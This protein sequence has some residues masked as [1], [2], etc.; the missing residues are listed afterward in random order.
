VNARVVR[1]TRMLL[2][3]T[4]TRIMQTLKT[5]LAALLK[6]NLVRVGNP[7]SSIV[8]FHLFV[9]SALCQMAGQPAPE[10]TRVQAMVSS[11]IKLDPERPEY[12]RVKVAWRAP[13]A[14]CVS[15]CFVAESTGGQRSSRLL[16]VRSTVGLLELPQGTEGQ[17]EV[18]KGEFV[19]CILIDDLRH[20]PTS[21]A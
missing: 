2:A 12:H 5:R 3:V 8:C 15:G 18:T 13:D 6:N 4:S 11:D 1:R 21:C 16:S 9:R 10:L 7:V 17:R 19:P 20:M 14:S